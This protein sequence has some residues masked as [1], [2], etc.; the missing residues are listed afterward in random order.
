MPMRYIAYAPPLTLPLKRGREFWSRGRS[1]NPL[2][3]LRGRAGVGVY[4]RPGSQ[5][6]GDCLEHTRS[7]LEHFVVPKAQHPPTL[8]S[9]S[10]VAMRIVTGSPV[11]AA[12][13][14][15]N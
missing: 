9:Q 1:R 13:N 6:I 11:L 14:L 8:P 15:D 2:P 7:V 4:G 12:V 5:R 10:V 3:R